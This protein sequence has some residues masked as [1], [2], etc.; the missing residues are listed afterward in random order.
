MLV[1]PVLAGAGWRLWRIVGKTENSEPEAHLFQVDV[2]VGIPR[3]EHVY[4]GPDLDD[5][6]ALGQ[7][8]KVQVPH[9]RC[10]GTADGVRWNRM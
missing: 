6:L 3:G 7:E 4:R 1:L 5:V 9:L 2:Y 8:G 10:D